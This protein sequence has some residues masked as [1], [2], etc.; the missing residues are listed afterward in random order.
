MIRLGY[1]LAALIAAEIFTL[2]FL[3]VGYAHP[4]PRLLW[5][6]SASAPIGLYRVRPGI[7]P[8]LGQFAVILPPPAISRY[9]DKRRYL[10]AGIPLLK[11]IA[12]TA[13]ARICRDG[14]II[15]IDGRPAAIAHARDRQGRALPRWH[16]CWTLGR[17]ELFLLNAAP[18]SF[19]GRYFGPVP[20]RSLIGAADPILI[21]WAGDAPLRWQ[22]PA[23]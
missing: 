4:H 13:G 8:R 21:R 16:G 14:R 12:A 19:D 17:G 3:A 15:T 18:D 2:L 10:P 22:R 9:M 1:V 7:S 6:A 5:N 11:Q 23:S 20:A